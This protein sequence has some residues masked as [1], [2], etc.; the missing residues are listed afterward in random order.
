[1]CFTHRS[2]QPK[3]IILS[4][5]ELSSTA[6]LVRCLIWIIVVLSLAV[7]ADDDIT[8]SDDS[9]STCTIFLAE[10][11]IP[12]AGFG[13]YTTRAVKKGDLI[14]KADAPSIIITDIGKYQP[15]NEVPD[16]QH[17]NYVWKPSGQGSFEALTTHESVLT[18]GSLPNFHPGLKSA[19]PSGI[20]R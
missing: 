17:H 8:S 10:S 9:E 12:N 18:F 4:A 3:M 2:R 20:E 7:K 15:N 11:T 13:I 5:P 6:A 16:W 19:G 1:M 14:L